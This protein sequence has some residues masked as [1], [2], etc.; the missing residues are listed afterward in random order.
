MP[1]DPDTT[2]TRHEP[3]IV[4][5][6]SWLCLAAAFALSAITWIA[7]GRIAGYGPLAYLMPLVVD[8]Y[9]IG[10][11]VTW[12][13]PVGPQVAQFAYWNMYGAAI[14]GVIS[15]AIYHCA[16]V[17]TSPEPGTG[18]VIW[19]AAL[20]LV[21]GGIPPLFAFLGV[22]LRGLARRELNNSRTT[23]PAETTHPD[24][25]ASVPPPPAAAALPTS[26]S[27]TPR[28]PP[29][30]PQNMVMPATPTAPPPA[31]NVP[32]NPPP[33]W[34]PQPTP[35]E[36]KKKQLQQLLDNGELHKYARLAQCSLRTAQRHSKARRDELETN[37]RRL[38]VPA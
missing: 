21:I 26:N 3:R 1:D 2:H 10:A 28:S 4:V 6:V 23:K 8:T 14:V 34:A 38:A 31:R 33:R 24:G 37:T 16:S 36:T 11:I 29:Q 12:L 18:H 15:Q 35:H 13:Q 19:K 30:R 17:W 25:T 5:A 20:A 9:I 7:L 32:P 27:A 22:H